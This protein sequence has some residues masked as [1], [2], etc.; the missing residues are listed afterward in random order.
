MRLGFIGT[1]EITK[2]TVI[3][4]LKSNIKLNKISISKR[5]IKISKFLKKKNSK[6]QIYSD[7]QK[8][9]DN[10]DWVFLAITPQVAKK[11]LK[12]LKFKKSKKIISFISTL[13][14][15]D[16]KFITKNKNI[17]RVIPLPFIGMKKGPVIISP[18]DR[19]AKSFF[20]HLGKVI[21]IK[22]EKLSKG[23]WTTSSFMAS[24]YN[25]IFMT[26]TWL[27]SKGI[28]QKEADQYA[29]ELFLALSEDAVQ[30]KNINLKQLVS[31]SQTPGGTNATVLKNLK[32]NRFYKIQLKVFNEIFKKF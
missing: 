19:G 11:I 26:S 10:S 17:I 5:N 4:I 27:V 25:L 31:E 21:E 22:S 13:K 29:K 32:K 8:I 3:G 18:K 2:A 7:N 12:L 20:K 14:I 6:I 24:F 15:K 23:F 16:L 1:G 30:K 9:L 28:K